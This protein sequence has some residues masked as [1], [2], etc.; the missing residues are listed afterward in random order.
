MNAVDRLIESHPA[1][2]T[3]HTE[4]TSL[5]QARAQALATFQE[6]G[7]P[8]TKV[9][10]WKYTSTKALRDTGFVLDNRASVDLERPEEATWGQDGDIQLVFDKGTLHRE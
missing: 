7:F 2:G 9:E 4:N 5:Q 1:H 10:D 6:S 8:S 3:G